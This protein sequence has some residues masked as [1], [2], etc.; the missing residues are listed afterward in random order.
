MS[1]KTIQINSIRT[2]IILFVAVILAAFPAILFF[3]WSFGHAISLRAEQKE[4]AEVSTG[5]APD[6]PKTHYA[7]A[8]LYEK[9][10][11]PGDFEKSVA[12]YEKAAALSPNDF[13]LW[14][15]LGKAR[16][17]NGDAVGA[18]K[19]LRRAVELAPNYVDTRWTLGNNLL[20]QGK[21]EEGFGEIRLAA[22]SGEKYVIPA[23][24]TA[25]TIFN[26]DI[27][28]IRQNIGDSAKLNSFLAIFL[29]NQNRFEDA[30]NVWNNLS[31]EAKTVDFKPQSEEIY[32]RL[33][34][35]GKYRSAKIVKA[36][37]DDSD[38][39]N[40]FGKIT[41]GGFDNNVK[42]DKTDFFDWQIGAGAQPLVGYDDKIKHGGNLSLV[43]IFNSPD[44]QD[45]RSLTQTVA[46]EVGKTYRF[47][48]FYKADLKTSATLRWEVVNATDNSVISTTGAI[49]ANTDW[50]N[51]ETTFTVPA[52]AEAVIIRLA[53]VQCG[54]TI[55]P[56]NGKVWFD[57]FS[58]N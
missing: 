34:S 12:E 23:I 46:V 39:K 25:W 16:E 54:T 48:G 42:Q 49:A 15:A 4:V 58:I 44:G 27:G 43:I 20:R 38:E 55:C 51:F 9:S 19:A 29:L 40:L 18:E 47:Q 36:S 14:L 7:T 37:L 26:G 31:E 52:N 45:F 5:F 24:S 28:Q 53:R 41:S 21:F 22:D 6:D 56:I 8:V 50:T 13:L 10:F 11:L 30:F 17:R 35:A 32:N 2:K 1:L 57:D 3:K 33:I